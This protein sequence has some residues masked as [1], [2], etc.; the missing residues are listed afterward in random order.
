MFIGN[1][2]HVLFMVI[3]SWDHVLSKAEYWLVITVLF[4][5]CVLSFTNVVY[6]ISAVLRII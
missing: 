4:R 3:L 6:G 1:N 2:L 5:L